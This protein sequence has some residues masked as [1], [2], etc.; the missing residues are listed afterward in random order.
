MVYYYYMKHRGSLDDALKTK[1]KISSEVF[2]YLYH[3]YN[4]RFYCYDKR[5]RCVRFIISDMEK[6]INV[7][8]CLLI[9]LI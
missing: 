4:Y 9:E 3:K 2:F 5:I 6:N 8:T 1:R 7:P